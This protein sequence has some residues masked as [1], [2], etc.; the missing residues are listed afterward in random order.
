MNKEEYERKN[1]SS[2]FR[3]AIREYKLCNLLIVRI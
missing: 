1:A 3:S 2:I